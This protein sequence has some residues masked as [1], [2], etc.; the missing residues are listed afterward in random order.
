MN[1]YEKW[2]DKQAESRG[3][4]LKVAFE[5]GRRAVLEK[6]LPVLKDADHMMDEIRAMDGVDGY[7]MSIVHRRV[8]EVLDQLVKEADNE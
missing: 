4:S 8:K 3:L 7:I 2:F 5:G 6:V 1:D